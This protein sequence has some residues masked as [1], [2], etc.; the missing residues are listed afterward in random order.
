MPPRHAASLLSILFLAFHAL[1]T[2]LSADIF[3]PPAERHISPCRHF[4]RRIS[5]TLT[6]AFS[7]RAPF[8]LSLSMMPPRAC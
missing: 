5:I 1:L 3:T 7:R 6:P 2:P 8:R 4:R